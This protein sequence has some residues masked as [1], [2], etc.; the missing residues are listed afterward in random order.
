MRES[1]VE[2]TAQLGQ[3]N[4]D[5]PKFE[6]LVLCHIDHLG[7]MGNCSSALTFFEG[8]DRLGFNKRA[9]SLRRLPQA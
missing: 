1:S 6:I 3:L 4:N 8:L 5:P 2:L 9:S 7:N